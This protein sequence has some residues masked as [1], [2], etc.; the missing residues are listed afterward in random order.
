MPNAPE[1]LAVATKHVVQAFPNVELLAVVY[2]FDQEILILESLL[3][4]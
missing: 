2:D 4:L 1:V 3:H